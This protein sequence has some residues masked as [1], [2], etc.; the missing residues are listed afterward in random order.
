M[1]TE[2]C[3]NTWRTRRAAAPT[4]TWRQ[5]RRERWE[6]PP[7]EE[8][9]DAEDARDQHEI[10]EEDTM[11]IVAYFAHL[12]EH[13]TYVDSPTNATRIEKM[14]WMIEVLKLD[15]QNFNAMNRLTRTELDDTIRKY[16]PCIGQNNWM[17]QKFLDTNLGIRRQEATRRAGHDLDFTVWWEDTTLPDVRRPTDYQSESHHYRTT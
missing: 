13:P 10:T 5:T 14:S 1:Q 16:K 6:E 8:D 12:K 9:L 15:L 11:K 2:H 7:T 3:G 4:K 17:M